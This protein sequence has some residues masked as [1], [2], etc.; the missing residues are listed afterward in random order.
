[1]LVV[2]LNHLRSDG[3]G[4]LAGRIMR[5]PAPYMYAL[6]EAARDVALAMDPAFIKTLKDRDIL[7]GFEGSFGHQHVSPRGL[8]ASYLRT[9]VCVE[10]IVT[11]CTSVR[12]KLVKS[13]HFN[14]SNQS[15]TSREYRDSTAVE[16]GLDAGGRENLPTTTLYP[17]KDAEGNP[18]E[19]E[20]GLCRFKDHQTVTIQV[21]DT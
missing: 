19:T 5:R 13:V 2:D 11:K 15:F 14:P 12:P 18:L 16:L 9:L 20:Y 4:D 6:R 21:H 1:R 10:G 7:I 17:T 3:R 8:L